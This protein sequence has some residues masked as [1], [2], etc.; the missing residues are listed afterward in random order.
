M[1]VL[2]DMLDMG[3]AVLLNNGRWPVTLKMGK[4]KWSRHQLKSVEIGMATRTL[5]HAHFLRTSKR[6]PK[7]SKKV[8]H[9]E[10]GPHTHPQKKKI[11]I[12]YQAVKVYSFRNSDHLLMS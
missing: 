2:V 5:L 3:Q 6:H 9:L 8:G 7:S 11:A 12:D 10:L 4:K 1:H